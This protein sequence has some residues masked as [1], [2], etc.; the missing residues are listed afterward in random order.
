MILCFTPLQCLC[1]YPML[2]MNPRLARKGIHAWQHVYAWVLYSL[3]GIS[4]TITDL[5]VLAWGRFGNTRLPPLRPVDYWTFYGGKA[6]HLL[7]FWIVPFA[8][9][10]GLAL[11]TIFLPLFLTGGLFVSLCI[12][13]S[14][15]VEGVQYN[16]DP[17]LMDW[18]ELQIRTSANW[19]VADDDPYWQ[20]F[21]L[22]VTGG[23]NFQIEHHLFPSVSHVHYPAIA[24]VVRD[25]CRDH[26][27]PY[28]AYPSWFAMVRSHYNVLYRLGH[29]DSEFPA[30]PSAQPPADAHATADAFPKPA[31][32]PS[33]STPSPS[34]APSSAAA[35][36]R[37]PTVGA[38]TLAPGPISSKV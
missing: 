1:S 10:G 30:D 20:T 5:L 35:T 19:S 27:I 36:P 26:A 29:Q 18:A 38:A 34:S 37:P 14:H 6:V 23:L 4:F 8:A 9:H 11:W 7:L 25:V 22:Y 21:W 24:R 16:I 15:N 13:T 3:I 28:T 17:A 33:S 31:P 12:A 32:S 2:R